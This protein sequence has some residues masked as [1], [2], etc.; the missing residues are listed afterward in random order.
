[1]GNVLFS[2][3]RIFDASG[4][5]PYTGE[6]LVQGNRIARI[7]RAGART[8]PATGVRSIDGGGATL[9]PGMV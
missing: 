5:Q 9:M 2:N 1:M 4:A 3:V 7:T 6:V 8:M